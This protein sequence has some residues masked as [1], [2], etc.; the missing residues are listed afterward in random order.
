MT[1][2]G[3]E[4]RLKLEEH[5]NLMYLYLFLA[6]MLASSL[7]FW[8]FGLFHTDIETARYL[9]S[10][11]VQSEAA[12]IAIVITLSLVAVQL[13]ASSYSPRV[14]DIFRESN[15][16]KIVMGSYIFS[17]MVGF[18]VLKS[19]NEVYGVCTEICINLSLFL[20]FYCFM[21]LI[22]YIVNILATLNPSVLIDKLSQKIT[23]KTL[24]EGDPMQLII[25]IIERFIKS[26]YSTVEEGLNIIEN[27]ICSI[28]E[29]EKLTFIEE[30]IISLKIY[31]HFDRLGEL[32]LRKKMILLYGL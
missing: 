8:L 22:P 14:I 18:I 6:T 29:K 17:M 2:K 4:R 5:P 16:L 31:N 32:A 9:L 30:G 21:A 24:L 13:T 19:I 25:N 1:V 11:L 10:A 23:K 20:G 28:F 26:D 3:I 7:V 27:K 12:I 15:D